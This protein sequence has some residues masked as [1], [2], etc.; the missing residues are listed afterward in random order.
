MAA[1]GR[2]SRPRGRV[3]INPLVHIDLIGTVAVPLLMILMAPAGFFIGWANLIGYNVTASL[4]TKPESA[5][6][7]S[8]GI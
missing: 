1:S 6:S 8:T 7:I 3:S 2:T 4:L 5:W